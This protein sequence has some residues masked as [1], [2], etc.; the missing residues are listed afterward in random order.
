MASSSL[1]RATSAGEEMA[2]SR[3]ALIVPKSMPEH[4]T[5]SESARGINTPTRPRLIQGFSKGKQTHL[6]DYNPSEH[7]NVDGVLAA[8]THA[9]R[10]GT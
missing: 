4:N 3:M 5:D 8:A 1:G 7:E 9:R 2:F 10:Y 6:K